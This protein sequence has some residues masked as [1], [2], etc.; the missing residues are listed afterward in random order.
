MRYLTVVADYSQSS[1]HDD[2]D[3]PVE[4]E[5]LHLPQALCDELRSWNDQYRTIIPLGEEARQRTE[6]TELIS[7]L[8]NQGQG[9]AQKV[10][11]ALKPK[12]KVR[13]YSEGHM[14]YANL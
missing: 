11:D 7:R 6:N 2:F 4:P 14:R 3:G 8:D 1:L 13:Y 5:A 9:L 10:A 12:V